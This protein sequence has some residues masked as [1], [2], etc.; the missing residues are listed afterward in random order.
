MSRRALP[1]RAPSGAP[2]GAPTGA[3]LAALLLAGCTV[4]PNFARPK[5]DAPA[6]F[7]ATPGD[8]ASRVVGTDVDTHWWDSFHDA[9]LSS[10]VDRLGKQNL[11]LQQAAE[12]ITEARAERQVAASQ[13]LPHLDGG[14][15]Y[16]RQRESANGIASL[17]EPAPGAPLEFNVFRAMASASWELDL[18]GRV[19]RAVEAAN[20]DTEAAVEA[21]HGLAL[22]AIGD[23]AQTYLQLRLLQAQQ[24]VLENNLAIANRRRALIRDR[25]ANGVATTLDVAQVDSQALVI[26]QDLP[27]LRAQQARLVNV[28]GLLLAEPPRTLAAELTVPTALPF[29]PPTVPVGLPADLARRRPDV[30]EAEARL[31]AATAETG[32]AVANFYPDVTLAGSFGFESL[33]L[34]SLFDSGSR[35]FMV[36]PS[37]DVPI[38]EGGRLKGTLHLREAQ[39]REAALQFRKVVLQA[40]H[41]VDNAL[42]AYAEAQHRRRDAAAARDAT[43]R[44]LTAAEQQYREGV[45]SLLDVVA[46]QEGV[47]RSENGVAQAQ[48]DL[49]LRLVDLY[50]ALG[51]G[52]QSVP[53]R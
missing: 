32:V 48:A 5:V 2:T 10:L 14:G 43:A 11:D 50:R 23:L 7:G 17:T 49:A 25:F 46:A 39:Q 4:G 47:L 33:H 3:L 40:W 9:E 30:R 34:G 24:R 26:A 41:D 36:G 51:G 44:A 6:R 1:T 38:F 28:I 37:V 42:V 18:F 53:E 52:W 16:Q 13:G 15:Q 8:V 21:R 45:T 29:V 35:A 19:R 22:S 12:R 31:H 20:A 27:T